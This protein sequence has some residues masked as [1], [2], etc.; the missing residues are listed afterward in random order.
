MTGAIGGCVP[1]GALGDADECCVY[2]WQWVAMVDCVRTNDLSSKLSS[3]WLRYDALV[4]IDGHRSCADILWC[5]CPWMVLLT[6]QP[7]T[8]S[9]QSRLSTCRFH[10]SFPSFQLE[11]HSNHVTA[12]THSTSKTFSATRSNAFRTEEEE[13][14]LC[15]SPSRS[16]FRFRFWT[17]VDSGTGGTTSTTR[18]T[19]TSS[20]KPERSDGRTTRKIRRFERSVYRRSIFHTSF[21]TD[22]FHAQHSLTFRN[23]LSSSSAGT[24]TTTTNSPEDFSGLPHPSSPSNPFPQSCFP[25]RPGP[26]QSPLPDVSEHHPSQ[27]PDLYHSTL[28]GPI[29]PTRSDLPQPKR[30]VRS[31]PST[32][33]G[34]ATTYGRKSSDRRL[35]NPRTT[36]GWHLE[37]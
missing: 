12:T 28:T 10:F 22:P 7:V 17:G 36:T 14:S 23:P 21:T 6:Y 35:Q 34:S 33:R 9:Q 37:S 3:F 11:L 16:R 4:D 32:P 15:R 30:P 2:E 31:T 8:Y 25:H 20:I 27:T 24:I 19:W 5:A 13:E 29:Q 1:H 26:R 18:A